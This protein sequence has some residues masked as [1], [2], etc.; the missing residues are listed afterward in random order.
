LYSNELNINELIKYNLYNEEID[1]FNNTNFDY[2][3]LIYY[4]TLKQ[5]NNILHCE[6]KYFYEENY[7]KISLTL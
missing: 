2:K 6:I 7:F 4:N 1:L 5:I 3:Y